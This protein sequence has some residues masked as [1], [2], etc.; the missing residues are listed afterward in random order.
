VT[1]TALPEAS[2]AS[3]AEKVELV[4]GL[5]FLPPRAGAALQGNKTCWGQLLNAPQFTGQEQFE[6]QVAKLEGVIERPC[7]YQ[8][9]DGVWVTEKDKKALVGT[10]GKLYSFAGDHYV[11]V[12]DLDVAS[13]FVKA[14]QERGLHPVGRIDGIGTG[15][16]QGHIILA[17]PGFTVRLLDDYPDDIMLGVRFQNSYTTDT[18]FGAEVFGIRTVCINYNL[19][20]HLIGAF[21]EVHRLTETDLM[22]RYNRVIE[23]ALDAAPRLQ[24][25]VGK[26]RNIPVAQVDV[27]DLL[28]GIRLPVTGIGAIVEDLPGFVPEVKQLGLNAYTLYNAVTCYVS[29]RN[30]S[31]RYLRATESYA[32][33]ATELLT[34]SHDRLIG[35]GRV[36][37][38]AYEEAKAERE[39]L[40]AEKKAAGAKQLVTVPV[41]ARKVA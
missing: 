27:E 17:D 11:P 5:R 22:S 32:R 24:G 26:A 14:V 36:A 38:K 39:R 13:P 29:Y 6:A 7:G 9:A 34:V 30:T 25:I 33:R 28:W 10:N 37:K 1:G 41:E 23:S 3:N 31:A 19:W 20:G 15:R 2:A 35:E 4:S 16:T 40:E 21:R 12:Q 18:S 8:G